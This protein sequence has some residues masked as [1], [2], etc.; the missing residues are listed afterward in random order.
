VFVRD[1]VQDPGS[2]LGLAEAIEALRDGLLQARASGAGADMQLPVASMTVELK[3]AATRKVDGK[4]GFKV[5]IIN[6]ELGAA[7]GW[8]KETLQTVTIVFS[9]PVDGEGRPVKVTRPSDEPKG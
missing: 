8:Q 9:E 4:A 1:D 7:A 3:V 5:P 2:E 6:A